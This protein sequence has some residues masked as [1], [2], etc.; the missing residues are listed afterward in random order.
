MSTRAPSTATTSTSASSGSGPGAGAVPEDARMNA[1]AV[2]VIVQSLPRG[3]SLLTANAAAILASDAEYRL[4]EIIQD[5]VKFMKHS[6]RSRLRPE[7]VNAALRL[8]NVAPTFGFGRAARPANTSLVRGTQKEVPESD[9]LG[10]RAADGADDLFYT[11]DKPTALREILERPLPAVPIEVTV[12]THWLAVKGVQP[13]VPQNPTLKRGGDET[14]EAGDGDENDGVVAVKV[15]KSGQHVLSKELQLYFD[16][17]VETLSGDNTAQINGVLGSISEEPGLLQLLPYFVRHV[18]DNVRGQI[19][20]K[21]TPEG[22]N[23]LRNLTSM[24]RLVHALTQN[25]NFHL[26]SYLHKLFASV[27]TCVIAKRLYHKPREDHWKL[28]DYSS[29]LLR[30]MLK[31]TRENYSSLQSRLSKTFYSAFQDATKSLTTHYGA[32]VGIA[33]LGK[34]VVDATIMEHLS[35]YTSRVLQNLSQRQHKKGSIRRFEFAKV[36][37]AVV[38]AITACQ[39]SPVVLP[40]NRDLNKLDLTKFPTTFKSTLTEFES[41]FG[42]RI[43]PHQ[44][45]PSSK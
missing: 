41:E 21:A 19:E 4:R 12:S 10:W 3:E 17:M 45:T 1:T 23:T 43:Y 40:F 39:H 20:K 18:S 31:K 26:E 27:V 7:D 25:D 6:K 24:M 30:D 32:V 44:A 35:S 34:H 28:R 37:G 29:S 2:Q 16:N 36:L 13:A 38:F 9:T 33:T 15:G 22:Q 14:K 11:S 8:R 5:S 42:L